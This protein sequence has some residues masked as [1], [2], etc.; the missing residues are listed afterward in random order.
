[1]WRLG[2]EAILGLHLEDGHL[3]I[4]PCIPPEWKGFEAWIRLGEE[5][6][7]VVVENPDQ[8]ATGVASMTVDRTPLDSNLLRL[9][10]APGAAGE[11]EVHV[12]LGRALYLP[13]RGDRS[14]V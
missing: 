11:R 5:R 9:V 14:A 1:M 7:H 6:V 2:T 13:G 10:P 12:R 4:D 8:V 3:R